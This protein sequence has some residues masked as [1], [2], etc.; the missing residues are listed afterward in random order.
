MVDVPLGNM[1]NLLAVDNGDGSFT[2]KVAMDAG[3]LSTGG[4]TNTELRAADVPVITPLPAAPVVGQAALA[5]TGVAQALPSLTLKNGVVIKALE[6]NVS[7]ICVG[8]AGVTTAING[9]GNGYPLSPGEAISFAVPNSSA[10]SIVGTAGDV[11]Y[12]AG[13]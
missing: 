3:A 10:L 8:N 4:L 11:F 12:F 1:T 13:N 5:A 9:T 2:L 7:H 6:T